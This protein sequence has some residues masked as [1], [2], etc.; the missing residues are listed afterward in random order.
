MGNA[1][2]ADIVAPFKYWNQKRANSA[3]L[4]RAG[5]ELIRESSNKECWE[6]DLGTARFKEIQGITGAIGASEY[7]VKFV[8][9]IAAPSSGAGWKEKRGPTTSSP[10]R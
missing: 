4:V 3:K 7:E 2:H 5:A 10:A 8:D 1:V 6:A 9:E